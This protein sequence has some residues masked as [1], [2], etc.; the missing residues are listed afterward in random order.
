[1]RTGFASLGGNTSKMP[2]RTENWLTPSTWSR[3]IYPDF[4]SRETSSSKGMD[5]SGLMVKVFSSKTFL[6]MVRLMTPW[7]EAVTIFTSPA[8]IRDNTPSRT[9]SYSVET[10]SICR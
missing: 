2:P 10:P 6:G 1:M 8:A 9:C 3:R 5:C 4:D 7:M